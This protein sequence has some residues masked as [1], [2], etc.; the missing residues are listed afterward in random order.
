MGEW[1]LIATIYGWNHY[2]AI[3]VPGFS[4]QA[5]CVRFGDDIQAKWVATKYICVEKK[6]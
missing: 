2:S 3:T 6:P 1:I 5:A 4:T